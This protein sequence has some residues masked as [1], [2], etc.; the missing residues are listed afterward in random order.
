M[1]ASSERVQPED[2]CKYLC[3]IGWQGAVFDE[4]SSH[5]QSLSQAGVCV[6]EL[7]V[8]WQQ[9]R[10]ARVEDDLQVCIFSGTTQP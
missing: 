2:M 4:E 3:W 5:C 6:G 8:I 1:E 7:R 9:G 10:F